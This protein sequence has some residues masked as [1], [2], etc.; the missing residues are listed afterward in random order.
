MDIPFPPAAVPE[1]PAPR[2][3]GSQDSRPVPANLQ[4]WID[5]NTGLTFLKCLFAPGDVIDLRVFGGPSARTWMAT[6]DGQSVPFLVEA[7]EGKTVAVGRNPRK[8]PAQPG[9]NT[10]IAGARCVAADFDHCDEHEARSRIDRAGFP[11]PSM[12]VN[13]GHGVHAY[14]TFP[15]LCED[16]PLVKRLMCGFQAVLKSDDQ[17][18]DKVHVMRLP[19]TMNL[20]FPDLPVACTIIGTSEARYDPLDLLKLIPPESAPTPNRD[21]TAG[22]PIGLSTCNPGLSARTRKYLTDGA[23]PGTRNCELFAAGCD[24]A[25]NG[26]LDVYRDLLAVRARRDGLD[27]QEIARTLQSVASQP[28]TPSRPAAPSKLSQAQ[29]SDYFVDRIQDEVR[30]VDG[31]PYVFDGR[32]WVKDAPAYQERAKRLISDL[33]RDYPDQRLQMESAK[34]IRDVQKLA[35]SAPALQAAPEQFDSDPWLLNVQNGTVD[36][37]T[38]A[39]RAHRS[40]DLLT[41][42]IAIDYRPGADCPKFRT[43]IEHLADDDPGMIQYLQHVC[44]HFAVGEL[45]EK[46]LYVLVG[47]QHTGKSTLVS[48]VQTVLGDYATSLSRQVIAESK[49]GDEAGKASPELASLRG[50][51]LGVI[52]ELDGQFRLAAGRVKALTGNDAIAYRGLYQGCSVLMNGCKILV[53]CNAMP[54]FDTDDAALMDRLMPIPFTRP[55]RDGKRSIEDVV[56][57]LLTER[58][59]IL[60][61]IIAGARAW[62]QGPVAPPQV[63]QQRKL[64]LLTARSPVDAFLMAVCEEDA[65]A[66]A[67]GAEL[68]DAYERWCKAMGNRAD[69]TIKSFYGALESRFRRVSHAGAAAFRGVRVSCV[70]AQ[71]PAG[72]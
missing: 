24:V 45:R 36:L 51:R 37:R 58:E 59:G 4:Q 29:V 8:D 11:T 71:E 39:L 23:E 17:I 65:S 42:C 9:T 13:S 30:F 64:E 40:A 50:R 38:G 3:L 31:D 21:A 69:H 46:K 32:R 72:Q 62:C 20:K 14:W 55:F 1:L 47:R 12:L 28:R 70:S 66:T 61:W 7:C 26:L 60:A 48:V 15:K 57:D 19:G 63:V 49:F 41:K 56:G 27:Q 33:A 16:L 44:G 53:T 68:Y 67:K 10:N 6:F 52:A 5:W 25:G 34:W 18:C 54:Q 2:G 22:L 35:T 43:F